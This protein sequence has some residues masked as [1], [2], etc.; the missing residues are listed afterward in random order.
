M[1]NL[2]VGLVILGDARNEMCCYHQHCALGEGL[3]QLPCCT[4]LEESG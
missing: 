2:T 3:V 4:L 1:L